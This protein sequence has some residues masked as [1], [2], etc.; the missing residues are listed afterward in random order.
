M[1]TQSTLWLPP[2]VLAVLLAVLLAGCGDAPADRPG[3]PPDTPTSSG[4][5]VVTT[6]SDMRNVNELV[7]A[8]TNFHQDLHNYVLF[9]SLFDERGDYKEGPASF[10]PQLA[11]SYEFS[12]DRKTV[13]VRLRPG[14]AWSDGAPITAEDVR[15]TWQAQTDP[16]IA[17][18]QVHHK[19]FIRD[20]EVV[21][22]RTV[23]FHF[24]K[25]YATQLIDLN[26]GVILPKHAWEELPFSEWR[27]SAEWFLDRLVT[28]GPY[29]LERWDPGERIVCV[30]NEHYFAPGKPKI[31]RLVFRVAPDRSSQLAMLRSGQ[32]HIIEWARPSD[33]AEIRKDPAIRTVRVIPR[34]VNGLFWN[35]SNPL[36]A[37]K[38]V[39][40]ALTLAM[41]RQTIID[42]TYYGYA[43][44]TDSPYPSDLW[45]FNSDMQPLPYDPDE[46]RRLLAAEGWSDSDGD[47]VLDRDGQRFSFEILVPAGNELREDMVVIVQEQLSRIGIE[48]RQR[49][50]EFNTLLPQTLAG[51]Y[52]VAFHGLGLSTDLDLTGFFHSSQADGGFNIAGYSNPETDRLLEEIKAQPEQLPAKELYDRLQLLI[53]E[54]LPITILYEPVRFIPIRKELQNTYPNALSY[55]FRI[56]DW[57]LSEDN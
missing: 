12:D 2:T 19:G 45:V 40:R 48:V 34:G 33:V 6:S 56:Q 53:Q 9:Q 55:L 46:A 30:R 17:W 26:L 32:A 1:R 14:I 54:D 10:E 35:L 7:A 22:E 43:S 52:E 24:T 18:V 21:D 49:S 50:L 27:T 39:R 8:G 28:S 11:E 36:F 16:D 13:T 42:T 23:R 38:E 37:S 31:E 5:V 20:V 3:P 57:E 4:T 51:D 47:G 41:D 44:V 15:W 25:V 29:R